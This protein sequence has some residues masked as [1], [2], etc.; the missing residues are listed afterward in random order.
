MIAVQSVVIR[1]RKDMHEY[2][3]TT[4][5]LKSEETTLCTKQQTVFLT[6]NE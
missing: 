6:R 2:E 4:L 1:I 3:E 5:F